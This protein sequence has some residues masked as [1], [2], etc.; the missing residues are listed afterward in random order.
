[1]GCA[2]LNKD[3]FGGGYA[4]VDEGPKSSSG[5][6]PAGV[7]DGSLRLEARRGGVDEGTRNMAAVV[8]RRS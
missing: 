7:V 3:L 8:L 1:M 4:G 2:V 5:G 6:G